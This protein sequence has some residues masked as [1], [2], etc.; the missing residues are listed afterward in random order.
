M[1]RGGSARRARDLRK[2]RRVIKAEILKLNLPATILA[3]I[4]AI[5]IAGLLAFA[6]A[7]LAP[8]IYAQA[9][10]IVLGVMAVTS[11]YQGRQIYV[12]LTAMP[13]RVAQHLSKLVALSTIAAPTAVLVVLVGRV[14]E[15]AVY[16]V[17]TT[18]ISASVASVVR[19]SI[20]A[21]AGLLIYYFIISPL[22]HDRTSLPGT[23]GYVM[24]TVLAVGLSTALFRLRDA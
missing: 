2:E 14:S 9:G 1:G 6:K 8:V 3:I 20:P 10:F 18:L 16:L 23:I 17:L 12:T 24:W 4:G 21:V 5:G 13:R 11:E 15:G 22:L 19:R 7:G